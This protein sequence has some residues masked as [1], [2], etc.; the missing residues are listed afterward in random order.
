MRFLPLRAAPALGVAALA[1]A[2]CGEPATFAEVL[3]TGV[4]DGLAGVAMHVQMGERTWTGTAGE[5]DITAG[6]PVEE[7]D[8]FLLV[9][10][11]EPF[12]AVLA[13]E[14][15]A[16]GRF[17]LDDTLTSVMGLRP[18]YRVPDAQRITI[19]HALSQRSGL[20]NHLALLAYQQAL[21]GPGGAEPERIWEPNEPLQYADMR[22]YRA[23]YKPGDGWGFSAT[24]ATILGL[25][26][27]TALAEDLEDA[28]QQRVFGP[29]G[30]D[31]GL[32]GFGSPGPSVHGYAYLPDTYID[33]ASEVAETSPRADL[34]DT[35]TVHPSW[36]WAAG[37]I[38]C[39][40]TGLGRFANALFREDLVDEA[41]LAQLT[42]EFGPEI[43]R[44]SDGDTVRYGLGLML[45]ETVAGPAVGYDGEALGYGSLV[46][47]LP[48]LDLTVAA[49]T[50][51]SGRKVGLVDLFGQIV[52][53]I[54]AGDPAML[55]G[56]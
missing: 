45:R 4:S 15:A 24:N 6:T 51:T 36:A 33:L 5:S 2:A 11:S 50:N 20:N 40:A 13:L 48:D 9:G 17:A 42:G 49:V 3:N 34:Y 18:L 38:A 55:F 32:A 19:R 37:G 27:E 41:V 26:I 56:S 8:R 28:L 35:A 12:L 1:L 43:V 30:M 22:G 54:Q 44:E 39:S 16:E 29:A 52:A 23:I 53:L 21:L 25:I 31:A 46:Y 10:T 47:Y 7:G 14:L